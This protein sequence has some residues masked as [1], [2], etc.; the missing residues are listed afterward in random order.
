MKIGKCILV[1]LMAILLTTAIACGGGEA[2][3]TPTPTPTEV[4]TPTPVPTLPDLTITNITFDPAIGCEGSLVQVAV[5]IQNR[6]TL[7]SPACYWSWQLYEGSTK[8][9]N[10]LP[11]LFPGGT[12]VVHTQMP[13]ASDITG[14]IN[15]TAIVDSASEVAE[16]N[17]SNNQF[18]QPLTVSICDFHASY[19]SDKSKIQAALNAYKASHNGSVPVTSNSVQLNYPSGTYSIINVCALIGDGELL[20][21]VP[22]SCLDG[23]FDNCAT[24]TCTCKQ[25]ARYIWLVDG[26]GNVLSTCIGGD[27]DT[28]FADGYQGVWP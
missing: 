27:C 1:L 4:P 12:I 18:T 7:L 19:S 26:T 13:L 22:A 17:E 8:L 20:D 28:N 23:S 14:T 6:G 25:N 10:T 3:P 11:S 15:T 21:E 16:I 5:T 24:G 2:T 9:I